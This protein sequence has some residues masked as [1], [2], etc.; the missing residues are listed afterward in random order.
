MAEIELFHYHCGNTW[1]HKLNTGIKYIGTIF[2]SVSLFNSSM[3]ELIILSAL[4]LPILY[5][6]FRHSGYSFSRII[7]SLR[8]FLFFLLALSM[9]RWIGT[10]EKSLEAI[11]PILTYF[12][13]MILFVMIGQ[14][15]IST[16]DP[17]DLNSTVYRV[18]KRIPFIP[19]GT[20]TTMISLS[21]SFI[22]LIFDQYREIKNA[23]DARLGSRNRNP[24]RA[25]T[26]IVLPLMET[27][28]SRTD[29]ISAAMESRCYNNLR[30]YSTDPLKQADIFFLIIMS[31]L[32]F[33]I[34]FSKL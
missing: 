15:L 11:Y 8:G 18:L 3:G 25:I 24:L 29:E 2:L 9:L 10:E 13:K 1:F 7:S 12:W 19:A 22:P 33:F 5:I 4:L 30:T 16:T 14:A 20:I 34:F 32:L 23:T 31:L 17:S 26:M 27:S 21:I 28:L 6:I